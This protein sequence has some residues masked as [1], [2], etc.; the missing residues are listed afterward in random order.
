MSNEILLDK[1][2]FK[3]LAGETRIAVLKALRERRKTQAELAKELHLAAPT[4]KDHVTILAHAGLVREMDDG[5]KWKYI[6]LTVKGKG[7]LQPQ[8]SQILVLLATSIFGVAAAGYLAYTRF[9]ESLGMGSP[10]PPAD[11]PLAQTML[12]KSAESGATIAAGAPTMADASSQ[13][14][15]RSADAM[16]QFLP[17]IPYME[18][19]VV[20]VCLVVFGVAVGMWIKHTY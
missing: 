7:L 4:I 17:A 1:D 15:A 11:A 5:H 3:A 13:M 12:N 16:T 9:F 10:L 14:A 18:L 2:V 19:A 8:D 20:M 6:E